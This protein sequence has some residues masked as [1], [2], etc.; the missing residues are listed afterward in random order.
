MIVVFKKTVAANHTCPG[1][2]W[3]QSIAYAEDLKNCK[4][5]LS[6][7]SPPCNLSTQLKE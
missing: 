1:G 7:K 2:V 6:W 5:H 4:G 3:V